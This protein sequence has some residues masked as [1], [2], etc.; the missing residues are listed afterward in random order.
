MV[1]DFYLWYCVEIVIFCHEGTDTLAELTDLDADIPQEG[2]ACPSPHDNDCFRVH[3]GQ[4][5]FYGKT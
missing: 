3:F 5:E 4:L 1:D 2:A